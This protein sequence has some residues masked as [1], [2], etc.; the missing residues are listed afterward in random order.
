MLGFAA[1]AAAVIAAIVVAVVVFGAG[2]SPS[3]TTQK[4][5]ASTSTHT[6]P[7]AVTSVSVLNATEQE[8]LAHRVASQLQGKGYAR[9]AALDGKPSGA[10]TT[11]AVEYAPGDRA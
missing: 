5:A 10:L 7:A 9:A 4:K 8:G 2:K 3:A 1:V 11:T 6:L